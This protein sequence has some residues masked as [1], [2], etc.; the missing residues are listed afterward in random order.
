M[1]FL[2]IA[3]FLSMLSETEARQCK[4]FF[5]TGHQRHCW[6]SNLGDSQKPAGPQPDQP[7]LTE[8]AVSR[9]V[10]EALSRHPFP[11]QLSCKSLPLLAKYC[12]HCFSAFL[13]LHV[14]I[15]LD[16]MQ[17]S[18]LGFQ[19][20]W[21]VSVFWQKYSGSLK[22]KICPY[23]T[24]KNPNSFPNL[25]WELSECQVVHLH[26]LPIFLINSTGPVTTTS[27]FFFLCKSRGKKWASYSSGKK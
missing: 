23:F 12:R 25:E 13:L 5:S 9:T 14:L 11:P 3:C 24:R 22:I 1:K 8:P 17:E 21:Y 27:I 4:K 16:G 6:V 20:V 10:D 26:L 15:L 2:S 18:S 7:A 19:E